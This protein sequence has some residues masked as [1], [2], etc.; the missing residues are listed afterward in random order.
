LGRRND[1][2]AY[3]AEAAAVADA[4]GYQPSPGDHING[5][6]DRPWNRDVADPGNG[7]P[8]DEFG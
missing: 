7:P 1:E 2:L 4:T 5:E 3:A 8:A 6:R